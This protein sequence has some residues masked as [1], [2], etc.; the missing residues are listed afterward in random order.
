M[1]KGIAFLLALAMSVPLIGCSSDGGTS[2]VRE[3]HRRL[4]KQE[5]SPAPQAIKSFWMS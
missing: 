1:K 5:T 3:T 2:P 4:H